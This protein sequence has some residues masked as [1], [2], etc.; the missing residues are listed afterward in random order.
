M[1]NIVR[2]IN[3]HAIELE[4]MLRQME[5]FME[6]TPEGW[7]KCETRGKRTYYYHSECGTFND[8]EN[9]QNL[10]VTAE[11]KES[12]NAILAQYITLGLE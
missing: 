3:R 4:E 5:Q 6:N 11:E 1:N 7:L 2:E 12:I 8:K 9:N 10:P